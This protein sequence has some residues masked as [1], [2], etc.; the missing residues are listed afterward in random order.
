MF[1]R[2]GVSVDLV[3]TAE[4]SVSLTVEAD[5]PL[6]PLIEELSTFA[7]VEAMRAV[8]SSPPWVSA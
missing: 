2:R 8:P 6:K 4:V 5:V 7:K 3:A 1:G